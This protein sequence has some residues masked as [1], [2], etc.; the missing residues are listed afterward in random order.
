RLNIPREKVG[1]FFITPC[2][3]KITDLNNYGQP[4][5]DGALPINL[6]FGELN[7]LLPEQG[8]VQALPLVHHRGGG[9]GIGWARAGGESWGV[10]A[11]NALAVDGI[12]NVA[13]LLE[14]IELGKFH[15]IRY[16]EALACP[17]GC[18]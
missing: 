4:L 9:I 11:E 3:A 18:V 7:S 6:L 10:N 8:T 16:I 15:D 14:E 17:Q 5:V 12:Q 2:P 1:L 13:R